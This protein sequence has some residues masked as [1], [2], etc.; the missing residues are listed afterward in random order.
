MNGLP[1]KKGRFQTMNIHTI[2]D[3]LSVNLS[4]L[5][6]L[7]F[8]FFG[9]G[10]ESPSFSEHLQ[11]IR[12]RLPEIKW[13]KQ[14]ELRADTLLGGLD[15]AFRIAQWKGRDYPTV[16]YHHGSGENPYD[17]SFN[18]IFRLKKGNTP[19]NL[20]VVRAPF[21]HTSRE[22]MNSIKDLANFTAMLSVSVQV[23]E[24]LVLF[25]RE[26]TDAG[27]IVS[28]ISLGGWVANLHHAFYNSADKYK[29]LM[30]GA[31]LAEVFLD[32]AYQ[33]LTAPLAKENPAQLR[34]ILNF[35]D[36]F[37]GKDKHNVYPL[38]GL[39]DQIIRYDRQKRCYDAHRITAVEKGHISGA[40]DFKLLRN[41]ILGGEPEGIPK[42]KYNNNLQF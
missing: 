3:R 42:S 12:L 33:I 21:N 28:G 35:D 29:P 24:Q 8:K 38:L 34:R 32:S 22:Y 14:Y 17:R 39:Y 27:V 7:Q 19:A 9:S 2:L 6:F 1:I 4:A 23:I 11:N 10:I 30:A 37:A 16:I 18:H 26:R 31:A 20:I 36:Q 15:A 25:S 40:L 41:H 5:L 13:E